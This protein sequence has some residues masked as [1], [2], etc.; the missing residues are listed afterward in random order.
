GKK[1]ATQ[2][3]SGSHH[4]I[5][6]VLKQNGLAN[7]DI[8]LVN[9]PAS[10]WQNALASGSVDAVSTWEPWGATLRNAKVGKVLIDSKGIKDSPAVYLVRNAFATKNPDLVERF[11]KVN[12]RVMEYIKKNPD[13]AL[14]IVS[15]ESKIPV[16]VL[17]DSYR[18]TDWD[19]KIGSADKKSFMQVKEFLLERNIIKKDFD[20]ETLFDL[21]YLKNI[22]V[23]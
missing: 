12:Q 21:H 3:G 15:K 1:V 4:F 7:G 22:G 8:N 9:L 19:L 16:A 11:L 23:E 5:A 17:A 6:L 18:T 14:E 13:E 10:D 20:I 2:I